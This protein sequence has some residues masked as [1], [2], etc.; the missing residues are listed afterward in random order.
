MAMAARRR[1]LTLMTAA[2]AALYASQTWGR[3]I[4]ADSIR[5]WANE[6]VRGVRLEGERLGGSWGFTRRA[7]DAF[8][9][10]LQ[11]REKSSA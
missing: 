4:T 11:S 7:V 5:R 10:A 6:G 8:H 9:R 2:D 3:S 1:G